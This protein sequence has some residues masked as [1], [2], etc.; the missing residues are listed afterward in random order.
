MV[1]IPDYFFGNICVKNVVSLSLPPSVMLGSMS[2][3][4][5]CIVCCQFSASFIVVFIKIC[6]DSD[7][8]FNIN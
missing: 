5:V 3:N 7:I 2:V 8:K 4:P 1:V 6:P